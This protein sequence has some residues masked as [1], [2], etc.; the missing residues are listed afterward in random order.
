MVAIY[1][2]WSYVATM[3]ITPADADGIPVKPMEMKGYRLVGVSKNMEINGMCPLS[4]CLPGSAQRLGFVFSDSLDRLIGTA[5]AFRA[6][7]CRV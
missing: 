3:L 6:G 4:G 2:Q 5:G 1:D 7:V